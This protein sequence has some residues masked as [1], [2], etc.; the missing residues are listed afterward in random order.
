MDLFAANLPAASP[1][2]TMSGETAC[3]RFIATLPPPPI[4]AAGYAHWGHR[5]LGAV[6]LITSCTGLALL[7]NGASRFPSNEE[8]DTSEVTHTH[9]L[10]FV[11]LTVCFGGGALGTKH[12]EKHPHRVGTTPLK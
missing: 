10:T 12:G 7:P 2:Q 8:E 9:T 3:L 4:A 11:P 1:L 6:S 5:T